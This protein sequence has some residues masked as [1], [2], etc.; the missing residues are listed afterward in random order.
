MWKLVD[1]VIREGK[2]FTDNNGVTH[3]QVWARWSDDKKK[4]IGLTYVADPNRAIY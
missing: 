2:S 4:A 3:P 1:K